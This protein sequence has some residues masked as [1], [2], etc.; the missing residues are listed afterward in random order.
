MKKLTF[1]SI[2]KV[3][4]NPT[5][6]VKSFEIHV[7]I[8]SLT[9]HMIY[10]GSKVFKCQFYRPVYKY[11]GEHKMKSISQASS[12]ASSSPG[13]NAFLRLSSVVL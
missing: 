10:F 9:A 3:W 12:Y 8:T 1:I 11:A 13:N 7:V 2:R 6:F 4:I 5:M